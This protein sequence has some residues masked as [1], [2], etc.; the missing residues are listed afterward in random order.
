MPVPNRMP[1]PGA[2][3]FLMDSQVIQVIELFAALV[4]A[5][6]AYWQNCRKNQ[7]VGQ[8]RDA[9]MERDFA[10]ARAGHALAEKADVVSFFDPGDDT[11]THPPR[12]VPS[13]SW[14]MGDGTKRW[15]ASV[16]T[17]DEQASLL[18]QIA[19]AEEQK[20]SSYIISVPGAYYEIEYGLVKGGGKGGKM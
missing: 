5:I 15:I 11:V 7:A 1:A 10:E 18:R 8:K 19:E 9:D 12:T 4:A 6:I 2:E 16:H 20:K 13:R 14:K 3:V 17:P